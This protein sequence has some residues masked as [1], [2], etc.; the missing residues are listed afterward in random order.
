MQSEW[1]DIVFLAISL[2]SGA[3]LSSLT[4]QGMDL[5]SNVGSGLKEGDERFR[6]E[7]F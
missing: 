3:S 4:G 7:M 6:G 5:C 1:L 2:G